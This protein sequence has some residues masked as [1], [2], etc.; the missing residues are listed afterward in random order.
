MR[1]PP[2]RTDATGDLLTLARQDRSLW[3]RDWL[4]RGFHHFDSCAVGPELTAYHLEA[5]IAACHAAAADYQSTD[6][7]RI[8]AL[9]DELLQRKDSP[10]VHLNRAVAVAKVRGTDQALTALDQLVDDPSLRNYY[11]LPATRGQILW[12]RGDAARAAASFRRALALGCSEPER[13]FLLD[14]LQQ[15]ESGAPAV[16]W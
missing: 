6:W 8:L 13:Q 12:A 11:L 3:D 1:N 10:V 15:C 16:D 7:P 9:Y 4:G 5:A 2:A 14:R